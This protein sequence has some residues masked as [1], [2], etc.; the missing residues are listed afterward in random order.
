MD[1][2]LKK[3]DAI[4]Q[5]VGIAPET[6]NTLQKLADTVNND[7]TVLNTITGMLNNK[8]NTYDVNTQTQVQQVFMNLIDTAPTSLDTL[9]EFAT[10]L[11]GDSTFATTLHNAS[12]NKAGNSTTYTKTE[13]NAVIKCKKLTNPQPTRR[14]R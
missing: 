1:I 13:T 7:K 2:F 10:T 3:T 5:R 11:A 9:N 6:M 14:P 12:N 4:Q 8:A